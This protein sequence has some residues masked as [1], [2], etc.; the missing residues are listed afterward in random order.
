M[1]GTHGHGYHDGGRVGLIPTYA[2]NTRRG[3]TGTHGRR[4]HPHVCGEHGDGV[5]CSAAKKGSSPRMRGTLMGD[6]FLTLRHGLIPTYAGNTHASR[7]HIHASQAHP[8]VCGEHRF[9]CSVL[10]SMWGSSPRMRGTP[11]ELST[12]QVVD[13]LIPT[14]AGNTVY[15]LYVYFV[16]WAHPHVCGEH[17]ARFRLRR[18]REG[19]SPRMRGTHAGQGSNLR[20]AG[21][22]PTYAGNT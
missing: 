16:N 12:I 22:I 10:V 9:I 17:S 4:A 5:S 1:R 20:P 8:H 3:T 15:T 11:V 18:R 14:Y 6:H 19:S 21:L 2:G 7:A 13:G